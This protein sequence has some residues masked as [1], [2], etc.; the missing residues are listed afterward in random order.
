MRS[1]RDSARTPWNAAVAAF[2]PL[3]DGSAA[4][5]QLRGAAVVPAH[6]VFGHPQLEVALGRQRPGHARQLA[7]LGHGGV[8][9]ALLG[10]PLGPAQ[11]LLGRGGVAGGGGRWAGAGASV[12][13]PGQGLGRQRVGGELHV[14]GAERRGRPALGP[15]PWSLLLQHQRHPVAGH[16]HV[17][18]DVAHGG[19]GVGA[20]CATAARSASR[21]R[22][23]RPAACGSGRRPPCG[24][25]RSTGSRPRGRRP[26]AAAASSSVA[27]ARRTAS[28]RGRG[29]RRRTRSRRRSRARS[30]ARAAAAGPG[31]SS[32]L[33]AP[34]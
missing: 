8:E 29:C 27:P 16:R 19:G 5:Q 18:A 23:W 26:A 2:S 14:Q 12:L 31:P 34:A 28:G 20:R 22:R 7:Q 15:F 10:Q 17:G 25:P 1:T 21:P 6:L 33:A 3:N 9:Q 32:S 24:R 4:Q 30:R 13:R 11:A